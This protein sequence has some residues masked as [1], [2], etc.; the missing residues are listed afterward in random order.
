LFRTKEQDKEWEETR[1]EGELL[2]YKDVEAYHTLEELE[3]KIE[4]LEHLVRDLIRKVLKLEVR[5]DKL[6]NQIL[7]GNVIERE[8]PR[9]REL[10]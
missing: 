2:T 9:Y 4:G 7:G 3:E 10:A 6:Y 5:V 8:H 1:F